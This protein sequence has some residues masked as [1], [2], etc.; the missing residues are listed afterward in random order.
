MK[1]LGCSYL[2]HFLYWQGSPKVTADLLLL[3]LLSYASLSLC[4]CNCLW[5]CMLNS[6]PCQR[7]WRATDHPR[8]QQQMLCWRAWQAFLERVTQKQQLIMQWWAIQ[9]NWKHLLEFGVEALRRAWTTNFCLQLGY[10]FWK[11]HFTSQNTFQETILIFLTRFSEVQN[12]TLGYP[13]SPLPAFPIRSLWIVLVPSLPLF[14]E[15]D[16][17]DVNGSLDM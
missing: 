9:K 8:V 3:W 14:Q 15:V 17:V 7:T 13:M 4:Q 1:V 11:D 2:K 10:E 5:C 6:F 16:A 12:S